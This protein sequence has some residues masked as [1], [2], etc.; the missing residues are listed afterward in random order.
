[1]KTTQRLSPASA[2]ALLQPG[3]RVFVHAGP[4]E[5]QTFVDAIRADPERAR[6]VEL[7]IADCVVALIEGRLDVAGAVGALL[8]RPPK[9]E[10]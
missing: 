3:Q 10:E 5:C 9:G 2:L 6:G 1:M 7:P 4:S 8:G